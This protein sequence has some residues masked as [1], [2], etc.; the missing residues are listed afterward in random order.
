MK[1]SVVAD[2]EKQIANRPEGIRLDPQEQQVLLGKGRIPDYE[3]PVIEMAE[4]ICP[5]NDAT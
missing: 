2:R 4:P 1:V 3:A 5:S